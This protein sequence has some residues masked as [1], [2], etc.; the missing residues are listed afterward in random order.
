MPRD[1]V[2]SD[3]LFAVLHEFYS[4]ESGS[5][6]QNH[7]RGHQ[8]TPLFI[9]DA[10]DRGLLDLRNFIYG[11][12]DFTGVDILPAAHDH[13]FRTIDDVEVAVLVLASDISGVEEPAT[14][15]F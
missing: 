8:L 5:R 4:R 3:P 11:R 7:G 15:C 2:R 12:L 1:L 6:P 10:K 13:V 9:R 14:Q